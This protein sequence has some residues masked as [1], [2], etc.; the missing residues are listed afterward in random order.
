ME[1]FAY[2][3]ICF[4]AIM[5]LVMITLVI[6]AVL[7]VASERDDEHDLTERIKFQAREGLIDRDGRQTETIRDGRRV[8][9]FKRVGAAIRQE[10]VNDMVQDA[11]YE[12][13]AERSTDNRHS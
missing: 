2:F 12:N 6:V 10:P 11:R 9:E 3:C 5:A 8:E 13:V 7:K 1:K 4:V